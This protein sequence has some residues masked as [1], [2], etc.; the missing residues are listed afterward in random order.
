MCI[1]ALAATAMSCTDKFL[2]EKWWLPLLKT[3]WRPNRVWTN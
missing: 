3:I 1:G 2:E